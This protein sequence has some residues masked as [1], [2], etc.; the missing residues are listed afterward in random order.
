V[1][2][3]SC[4]HTPSFSQRP[5]RILTG[6]ELRPLKISIAVPKALLRRQCSSAVTKPK[7]ILAR[8][9]LVDPKSTVAATQSLI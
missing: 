6:V 8:F 7:H 1:S 4:Q 9:S 2:E 5:S 3:I